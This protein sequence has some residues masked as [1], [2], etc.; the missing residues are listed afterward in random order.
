MRIIAGRLKGRN[1]DSPG[2]FKTHPMSD[3]ARGAMFN[4]LGDIDGLTVL[5]AFAGSGAL[6]FEAMSRGAHSALAID[7]DRLAQKVIA[8]NI[9]SLGLEDKVKLIKASANGWL[10]TNPNATFDL[11]ICDPP[12]DN[13]QPSLLARLAARVE[14]DGLFVLS[15]PGDKEAPVFDGLRQLEYRSYGGA[16]LIFYRPED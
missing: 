14:E 11:V 9:A 10:Q 7:S 15:W 13:L 3:K 4:V 16:S 6:A 8:G 1:F 2:S 5:D 12:Y